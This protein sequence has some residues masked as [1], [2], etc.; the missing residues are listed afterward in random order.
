MIVLAA[1]VL[2]TSQQSGD[3]GAAARDAAPV[4]PFPVQ[5]EA[6]LVSGLLKETR[7]GK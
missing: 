6:L 2:P 4:R 1:R 3:G 7:H 5:Y